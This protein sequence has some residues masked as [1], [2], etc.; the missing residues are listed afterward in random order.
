MS[1][2][3]LLLHIVHILLHLIVLICLYILIELL[4]FWFIEWSHEYFILLIPVLVVL[5][6]SL[7][8]SVLSSSGGGSGEQWPHMISQLSPA[9]FIKA[10]TRQDI[11]SV[12]LSFC[13]LCLSVFFF[14]SFLFHRVALLLYLMHFIC[15]TLLLGCVNCFSLCNCIQ[16]LVHGLWCCTLYWIIMLIIII[17]INI[18]LRLT[19]C[20]INCGL[21]CD[22]F[23]NC[24]GSASQTVCHLTLKKGILWYIA[25]S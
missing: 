17:I 5:P 8:W 25:F 23:F 7:S 22:G 15:N 13:L 12:F 11:S 18:L 21:K 10:S 4:H 14:F 6:Y 1:T 19:D 2:Y 20:P 3:F 16:Y 9:P 24:N